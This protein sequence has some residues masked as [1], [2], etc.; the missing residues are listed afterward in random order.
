MTT[1]TRDLSLS[2]SLRH[3]PRSSRLLRDPRKRDRKR[4]KTRDDQRKERE[5]EKGP[6]REH[7]TPPPIRL[8]REGELLTTLHAMMTLIDKYYNAPSS[9][10]VMVPSPSLS[11]KANA[12]L[13]SVIC[14]SVSSAAISCVLLVVLLRCC[15]A[16][17]RKNVKTR[18]M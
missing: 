1:T 18:A 9:F 13:N 10:V 15:R 17:K 16:L 8:E 3:R 7:T 5:R 2:L 4:E 11:N 6:K 14:S 12:S